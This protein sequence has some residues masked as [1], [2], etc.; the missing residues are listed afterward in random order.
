MNIRYIPIGESVKKADV[1][2]HDHVHAGHAHPGRRAVSRRQ[3]ARTAAGAAVVGA[4]LGSGL[5]WPAS[6]DDEDGGAQPV[7]IPGGNPAFGGRF[8]VFGP[9][10]NAIPADAEPST[11]TDLNGFVGLARINGMVRRTDSVTGEVRTLPFV[12]TDM[13]FMKGVF[14]G[15]DGR[16]HQGA[17]ALV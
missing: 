13:R 17:F 3:F 12:D 10:R 15:T 1:R 4:T 5:W 16:I 14:R 11:I 6:A 9:G 7:P 8:H 2:Q